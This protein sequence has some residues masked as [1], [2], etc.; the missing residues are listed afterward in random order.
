[1][2][3]SAVVA[4]MLA[5]IRGRRR[6]RRGEEEGQAE[7]YSADSKWEPPNGV[8]GAPGAAVATGVGSAR[9]I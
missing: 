9:Y 1:M 8:R 5:I 2:V 4:A 6:R 7:Q 3:R